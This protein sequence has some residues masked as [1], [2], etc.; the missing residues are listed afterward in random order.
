MPSW[1]GYQN[2]KIPLTALVKLQPAFVSGGGTVYAAPNLASAINGLALQFAAAFP[3]EV[4]KVNSAYRSI[5][6]QNDILAHPSQAWGKIA[7]AGTSDHG[8]G[9]SVDFGSHISDKNSKEHKWMQDN[10]PKFGLTNTGSAFGEPGHWSMG[11]GSSG[12]NN[13]P[14]V[15][16]PKGTPSLLDS[17]G[18]IGTTLGDPKFWKRAG[19]FALG[20]LFII[21][22]IIKLLENTPVGTAVKTTVDTA[23]KTA[24]TAAIL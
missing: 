20:T 18:T 7:A 14:G 24:A 5:A 8:W 3:G 1:G 10:A 6:Q 12:N 9:T 23:A 19:L 17:F 22:V 13:T 21:I 4:L 2:G 16:T 15:A 11:T